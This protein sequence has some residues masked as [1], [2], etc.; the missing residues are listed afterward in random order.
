LVAFE[1]IVVLSD[2]TAEGLQLEQTT[3][4]PLSE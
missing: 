1:A 3:G 2:G 4:V